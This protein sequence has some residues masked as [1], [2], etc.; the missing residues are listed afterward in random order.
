M[1]PEYSPIN[2][3]RFCQLMADLCLSPD[4]AAILLSVNA[5]TIKRW[6]KGTQPIPAERVKQLEAIYTDCNQ[7]IATKELAYTYGKIPNPLALAIYTNQ[8]EM[9]NC[10]NLDGIDW[11]PYKTYNM[12]QFRL[13]DLLRVDPYNMDVYLIPYHNVCLFPCQSELDKHYIN[14]KQTLHTIIQQWA[15]ATLDRELSND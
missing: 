8:A 3:G 6:Y 10:V 2:H 11:L 13:A 12:M 5:S 14:Q 4:D 7:R 1:P 9:D 15:Q